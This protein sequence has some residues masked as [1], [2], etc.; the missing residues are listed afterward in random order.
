MGF[1]VS[2]DHGRRFEKMSTRS[3]YPRVGSFYYYTTQLFWAKIF[4][5]KF[6]DN[7]SS[8]LAPG[9]LLLSS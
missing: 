4:Q 1:S 5:V 2:I 3:N 6:L 9:Y 7:E 8:S